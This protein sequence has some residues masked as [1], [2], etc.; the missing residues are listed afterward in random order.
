MKMFNEAGIRKIGVYVLNPDYVKQNVPQNGALARVSRLAPFALGSGFYAYVGL[1]D[2]FIGLRGVRNPEKGDAPEVEVDPVANA[3]DALLDPNNQ[4]RAL[5]IMTPARA[6]G[7][8][9]LVTA[10]FDRQKQ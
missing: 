5:E 8:S 6:T 2:G 1:A 9:G 3:Y 7:L 10:Y 4:K